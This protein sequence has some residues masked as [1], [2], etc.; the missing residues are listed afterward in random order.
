[1]IFHY[2]A[3]IVKDGNVASQIRPHKM[4]A[5]FRA[6]GYDVFTITGYGAERSRKYKLLKNEMKNG[7]K[8]D[9][10]YSE[11][12]TIPTLLS[13]T[14][15][16]PTYPLLD[17]RIFRLCNK[18]KIPIG[19]FYRDIYWKF[20]DIYNSP[21]KFHKIVSKIF[22]YYDLLLYKFQL[23]I[24]F[25]PSNEMASYVP[26]LDNDK[27]VELPAGHDCS[28]PLRS[29]S[30]DTISLLY[31]GGLGNGY[32]M[33]ELFNALHETPDIV[34]TLCTREKDWNEN[35]HKLTL[36]SNVNVVHK[37]GEELIDLYANC[38]FV[39]L[40]LE[41]QEWRR[42]AFPFK[43]FEYL[44]YGKPIVT[45]N[46][47]PPARVVEKL[48]V[49]WNI[50]YNQSDIVKLFNN[51]VDKPSLIDEA[52]TNALRHRLSHDWQSRVDKVIQT[53]RV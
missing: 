22:H 24:C 10:M 15:H 4:L 36:P 11:A 25:L 52:T 16:F 9:F 1:M 38:D 8:F 28:L 31:V 13:E 41:P 23:D 37:S 18:K 50:E 49:G 40:I 39:S 3:P 34:L 2:P 14:H 27:C 35:K 46:D 44:G 51:L 53:L 47:S 21:N 26:L 45:I 48:G 32:P 12:L 20:D 30:D 43:F 6:S 5:T 7:K 33:Q 29:K 19:L 42:F 17:L